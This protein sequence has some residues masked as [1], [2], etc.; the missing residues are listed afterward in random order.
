LAVARRGLVE[1]LD[2][3]EGF[4]THLVAGSQDDLADRPTDIAV[5]SLHAMEAVEVVDLTV[6]GSHRLFVIDDQFGEP[7]ARLALIFHAQI[8]WGPGR[9]LRK[10]GPADGCELSV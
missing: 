9:A 10:L 3:D 7:K 4:R 8:S 2:H 5:A 1:E 6:I